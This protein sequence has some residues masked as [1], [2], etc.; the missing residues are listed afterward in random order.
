MH[1]LIR[2]ALQQIR[3]DYSFVKTIK[4]ACACLDNAG[5]LDAI[6]CDIELGGSS[7]LDFVEEVRGAR[8]ITNIPI[9]ILSQHTDKATLDKAMAVGADDYIIKPFT[10]QRVVEAINLW[11]GISSSAMI[12]DGLSRDQARLAR[13]TMATM[14]RSMEAAK[15]GEALPF[16][17]MRDNCLSI[18]QAG[19]D[20]DILSVLSGLKDKYI[21]I[22]CTA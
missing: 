4:D 5:K 2:P 12:L 10:L 3:A 8:K 11:T 16:Q 19:Y 14:G 7:G 21:D 1:E 22:S 15:V 13:L 9:I 6:I 20:S 18:L 17:M